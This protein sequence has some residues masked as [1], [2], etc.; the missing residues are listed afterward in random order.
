MQR[1][2]LN[3]IRGIISE[4]GKRYPQIH[5]LSFDLKTKLFGRV[6]YFLDRQSSRIVFGVSLPL[7]FKKG[8][9]ESLVK[10]V[11]LKLIAYSDFCPRSPENVKHM[12]QATSALAPEYLFIAS[13]LLI[14]IL[15]DYYA[16]H[17]DFD[18]VTSAL[19]NFRDR[20]F[21]FKIDALQCSIYSVYNEMVGERIFPVSKKACNDLGKKIFDAIFSRN[22]SS[23]EVWPSIVE[24]LA[25]LL[26]EV[27]L[28][29]ELDVDEIMNTT[30]LA[31]PFYMASLNRNVSL[32]GI[33]TE[34]RRIV[35]S[36]SGALKILSKMLP[37]DERDILRLWYRER[38]R[39][40][41]RLRIGVKTE[42]KRTR[43]Q[44]P[45][46]WSLGDS[47]EKLDVI[48]SVNIS[49]ILIPGYTTKKWSSALS[50]PISYK[51][52]VPDVVLIVDSSFSMGRLPGDIRPLTT[53]QIGSIKLTYAIG[54]KFDLTVLVAF[55][56][57]DYIINLGGK[58]AI[59]NFSSRAIS[60]TFTSN[61][62]ELENVAMMHQNEGTVFPV[63][64]IRELVGSRR[65]LLVIIISDAAFYNRKEAAE[66]LSWISRRND[67]YFI[68]IDK[69]RDGIMQFFSMLG[70]RVKVI[71][72]DNINKLPKTVLNIVSKSIV[73]D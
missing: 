61:K 8:K 67:V 13:T 46:T 56:V 17:L 48:L 44:Y 3:L 31:L 53:P 1:R 28:L 65:G 60:K 32:S 26:R 15:S 43:E 36:I 45:T 70:G 6:S 47:I 54:S 39:E 24:D 72:I 20:L 52:Y 5:Y 33:V 22:F 35:G 51:R 18:A 29:K 37:L 4:I 68:H 66:L 69:P 12:L 10:Y 73:M 59:I 23:P 21:R 57:V 34:I 38:V 58:L 27:V 55:A 62:I 50:A 19:R 42:H 41:V 64:K 71:R 9:L 7:L 25:I 11:I 16:I 14:E 63:K 30:E 49:P 2:A 40:L